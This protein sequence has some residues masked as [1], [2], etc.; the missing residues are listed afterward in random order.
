MPQ[1]QPIEPWPFPLFSSICDL[2]LEPTLSA[3]E[4]RRICVNLTLKHESGYKIFKLVRIWLA[5][6]IENISKK[7]QATL[8]S[9]L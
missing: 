7:A 5:W 1:A 4:G 8:I 6:L 2:E 3:G 9:L